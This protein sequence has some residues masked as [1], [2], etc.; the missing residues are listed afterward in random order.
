M[1]PHP[2]H[3]SIAKQLST[4]VKHVQDTVSLLDAGATVPFLAR[5]RKEATGGLD[6]VA[7]TSIRDRIAQLRELDK[8]RE[9][10]LRSLQERDLLTDNLKTQ[11]L[12]AE[13]MTVLED[14]YLPF[15]PKRRTRATMAKERGLEP[16]AQR[17]W[18]QDVHMDVLAEASTFVDPE[19]QIAFWVST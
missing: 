17:I 8:R 3:T 5:Y 9:V 7:I 13:S 4:S 2:H 6:E 10:I 11:I 14:L 15:R 1:I 18:A 19:K 16:L 12:S